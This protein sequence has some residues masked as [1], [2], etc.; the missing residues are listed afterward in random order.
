MV[1][2]SNPQRV[3]AVLRRA[4]SRWLCDDCVAAR[5]E[6]TSRIAISPI[7]SA[8]GL[9]SDFERQKGICSCCV[10]QRLVTRTRRR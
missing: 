8:L 5:A 3:V 9:T 7:A 10:Q 1:E 2:G 6:I 4:R